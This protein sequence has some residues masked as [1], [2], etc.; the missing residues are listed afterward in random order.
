MGRRGAGRLLNG[1][2]VARRSAKV[3]TASL[4]L[5]I[6][7]CNATQCTPL[8]VDSGTTSTVVTGVMYLQIALFLNDEAGCNFGEGEDYSYGYCAFN[9]ITDNAKASHGNRETAIRPQPHTVLV[10]PSISPPPPVS[11]VLNFACVGQLSFNLE[12]NVVLNVAAE[13]YLECDPNPDRTESTQ[14]WLCYFTYLD[15]S[16]GAA[17]GWG[18]GVAG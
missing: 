9:A 2:R 6:Q 14:P 11:L 18:C 17:L 8:I 13:D 16:A 1:E 5:P 7:G 12:N 4:E 10:Y 15:P 3:G